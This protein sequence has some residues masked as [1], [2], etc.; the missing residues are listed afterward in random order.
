ME[1]RNLFA[2]IFPFED[3]TQKNKSSVSAENL[4][5]LNVFI[6]IRLTSAFSSPSFSL[7]Q[8]EKTKERRK[9]EADGVSGTDR[10]RCVRFFSLSSLPP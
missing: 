10:K 6:C 7:Q 2:T 1:L 3:F 8:R 4:E 9:N 5:S